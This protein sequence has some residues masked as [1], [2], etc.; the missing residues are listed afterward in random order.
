MAKLLS[1]LPV[2][3]KV[4]D[5]G[6]KYNGKPITWLVGGHNHYV[7]GQTVLVSEKIIT[8]KAFDAKESDNTDSDRRLFGNNRYSLSNLRQWLNSGVDNWFNPQHSVDVLPNKYTVEDMYNAYAEE[9]GFL[10]NFST[11]LRNQLQNTSLTVAKNTITDGGGKETVTDKVFLLSNTEVGL[12]NENGIVEGKRLALFTTASS[13]RLAYPTAEAVSKSGYKDTTNLTT[14]KPW[15]YWLR[16]PQAGHS[17]RAR[18]VDLSGALHSTHAFSSSTGVRPALNLPSDIS[19]SDNTNANGEYEFSLSENNTD[20]GSVADNTSI[21]KYTLTALPVGTTVTE[22]I[23]GV[24]VGTKTIVN[25]TEYTVSATTAQWNAVKFGKYKD[26]LGN[27]N[28]VTLEVSTGE[29]YTYPFTKALPT[30]AK[31]DEVVM[32]VNDMANISMPSH[33]KKLVEAIGDKA[34]VGGTGSLEDIAKAVESIS[35][36]SLGGM[37][38]ASGTFTFVN[39]Y[40]SSYASVRGLSF[41]PKAIVWLSDNSDRPRGVDFKKDFYKTSYGSNWMQDDVIYTTDSTG[42]NSHATFTRLPNGFDLGSPSSYD[43]NK[44][45]RYVVFG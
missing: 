12:S 13:S 29:V 10:T 3:A 5:N 21:L 41:A 18:D 34:T 9:S 35:I 30:T 26:M 25:D 32:A 36:E 8:I 17:S 20:L 4:V 42:G 19:V 27:K 43:V 28:V 45:C 14:L 2:G 40:S 39:A 11:E 24:T 38:V 6:T 1:S 15:F 7:Q 23:N 16:S 22:K 33:K 37:K 31:T 44:T